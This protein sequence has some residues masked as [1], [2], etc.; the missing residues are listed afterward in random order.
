MVAIVK[1]RNW[2]LASR[3][4]LW[5]GVSEKLPVMKGGGYFYAVRRGR[6]PGIYSS[7][8]ECKEQVDRFPAASFK[9]F[10]SEEDARAFVGITESACCSSSSALTSN[11]C[12]QQFNTRSA[13]NGDSQ[14]AV[15]QSYFVKKRSYP[16]FEEERSVVKRRRVTETASTSASSDDSPHFTYMGDAVVV[17]TDGCCSNNG[18]FKARAGIGV[19]WG[20]DHPLNVSDR[21]PGRQTNQR[22]E[23]QAACRAI[24]QAKSQ[25]IKKLVIYTDSMFTINAITKWIK[26][27]KNKGWK[28]STGGPVVNKEDFERLDKLTQDIE[29]TWV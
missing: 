3:R 15:A 4:L 23:I 16:S 22:A 24:E 26:T 7:W 20:K 19:Y 2:Q 28:L 6:N 9:K 11:G 29:L 1:P 27:W 12:D 14:S 25:D 5:A 8:E 18:K 21:L 17:Y 13:R 10:A